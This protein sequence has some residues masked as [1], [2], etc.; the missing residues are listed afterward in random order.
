MKIDSERFKS[1]ER[2]FYECALIDSKQYGLF[3]VWDN[4]HVGTT[5]YLTR[6][7]D[8]QKSN[9]VA[10]VYKKNDNDYHII[11]HLP[12]SEKSDDIANILEMGWDDDGK[13][14]SCI[15]KSKKCEDNDC[16]LQLMIRIKKYRD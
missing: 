6:D 2:F 11:G 4:I 5:L 15:V 14:F 13:F 8:I 7:L 3:E 12:K 1:Q 9:T 10:V 16:Q